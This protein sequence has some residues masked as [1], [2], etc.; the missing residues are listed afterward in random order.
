MITDGKNEFRIK[1]L[2]EQC[3]CD[4]DDIVRIFEF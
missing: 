2:I 1:N 3:V 4:I